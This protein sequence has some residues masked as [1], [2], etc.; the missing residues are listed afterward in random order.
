[1]PLR[2]FQDRLTVRAV[3][4]EIRKSLAAPFSN[5]PSLLT[6]SLPTAS[7]KL[8]RIGPKVPPAPATPHTPPHRPPFQAISRQP[9]PNKLL[10]SSLPAASQQPLHEPTHNP[11]TRATPAP[12]A[13]PGPPAPPAP[14][15]TQAPP[16]TPGHHCPPGNPRPPSPPALPAPRPPGSSR[17]PGP[18][19]PPGRPGTQAPRAPPGPP[20]PPGPHPATPGPGPPGHTRATSAP[21]GPP[22][23]PGPTGPPRAPPGTPRPPPGPTRLAIFSSTNWRVCSSCPSSLLLIGHKFQADRTRFYF[24]GSDWLLQIKEGKVEA[25]DGFYKS[26]KEK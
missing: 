5:K 23:P 11:A 20:G 4:H 12:P 3:V 26:N 6:V 8:R 17:P 1:M 13:P 24:W 7:Q 21:P 9:P 15:V 16:A 10:R 2:T 19:G 14:P 18:P 25:R 22:G